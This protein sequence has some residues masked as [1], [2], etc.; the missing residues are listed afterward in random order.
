LVLRV[1]RV[2]V[3][4]MLLVQASLQALVRLFT[5]IRSSLYRRS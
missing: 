4:E 1:G 3:A 5:G 2:Y